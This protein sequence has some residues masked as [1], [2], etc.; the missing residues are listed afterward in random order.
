MCLVYNCFCG[1]RDRGRMVVLDLQLQLQS[2]PIASKIVHS[3][4]THGEVSSIQLD[5]IKFSVTCDR[6]VISPGTQL[7]STNKTNRHDISEILL[8]VALK[9]TTPNTRILLLLLSSCCLVGISTQ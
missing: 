8:K 7:S 5:V 4:P 1:R 6:S 3:N 2:V 9:T